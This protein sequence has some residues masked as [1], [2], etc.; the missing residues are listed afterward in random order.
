[1]PRRLGSAEIIRV[2]E[3]NGFRFISQ[4]GSH[5]KYRNDLGRTVIVPHPRREIPIGTTRSIIRQSGLTPKDFG[6]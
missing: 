6:F 2:L 3:A 5:V 4:R 1:M